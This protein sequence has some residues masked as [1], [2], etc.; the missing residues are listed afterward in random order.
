MTELEDGQQEKTV[1]KEAS[2]ERWVF[3]GNGRF[4]A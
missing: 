3:L 4:L 2:G 1:V